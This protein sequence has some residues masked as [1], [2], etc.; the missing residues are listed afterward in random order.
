VDLIQKTRWRS[1]SFIVR[2]IPVQNNSLAEDRIKELKNSK[3][4]EKRAKNMS[5]NTISKL[6]YQ[7]ASL[8]TRGF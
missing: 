2:L 3:G 4:V 7:F 1:I 6:H 8:D 5:G